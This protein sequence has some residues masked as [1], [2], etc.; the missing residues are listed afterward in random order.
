MISLKIYKN[1]EVDFVQNI[2][3]RLYGLPIEAQLKVKSEKEKPE[4]N[5]K[6]PNKERG[7]AYVYTTELDGQH[8]FQKYLISD[9]GDKFFTV[10]NIKGQEFSFLMSYPDY[11]KINGTPIMNLF[12]LDSNSYSATVAEKFLKIAGGE[13]WIDDKKVMEI[14]FDD[15]IKNTHIETNDS[16][17]WMHDKIDSVKPVNLKELKEGMKKYVDLNDNDESLEV[18]SVMYE[19]LQKHNA[20]IKRTVKYEV[21]KNRY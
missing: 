20:V 18:V 5:W 11:E 12:F 10:P 6:L 16:Y 4:Y 8:R 3:E 17:Y 13:M 14:P 9:N 19:H 21:S 15:L 1:L 7:Y 2:F